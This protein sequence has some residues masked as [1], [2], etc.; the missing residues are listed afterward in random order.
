MVFV[1]P[2]GIGSGNFNPAVANPNAPQSKAQ[3]HPNGK[4]MGMTPPA[5]Q[6][7]QVQK[8]GTPKPTESEMHTEMNAIAK[9]VMFQRNK[10]IG[11]SDSYEQQE[12][13]RV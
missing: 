6:H 8:V 7:E 1:S 9:G 11:G 4:P 5:F 12:R 2:F 10:S 13:L 3:L